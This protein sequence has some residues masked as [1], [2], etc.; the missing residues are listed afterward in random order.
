MNATTLLS[1][2]QWAEQTFGSVRLGDRRRTQRA[3]E[4][5][6]AMA[7]DPAA[8]LPAQMQGEAA[9]QAA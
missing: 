3:V 4:M 7:H 9:L 1:A 2:R 6:T 5:A 8:S